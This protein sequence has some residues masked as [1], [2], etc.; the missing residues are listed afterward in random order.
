MTHDDGG[1]VQNASLW[2]HYFGLA[3][4]GLLASDSWSDNA[5]DDIADMAADQ[6]DCM[7]Q[8]RKK[9]MGGGA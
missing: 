6:A 4:Q 1:R 3:M 7:I 5:P 9:R 8:E 2:D